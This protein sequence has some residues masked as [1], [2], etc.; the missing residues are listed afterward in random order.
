MDTIAITF[1]EVKVKIPIKGLTFDS[2][3]DMIAGIPEYSPQGI[4]KSPYR[5]R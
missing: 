3:E 2:I 1:P 5:Y 4:W